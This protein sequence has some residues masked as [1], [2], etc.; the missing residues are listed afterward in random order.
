VPPS[1]RPVGI[2]FALSLVVGVI[3]GGC[4]S[5]KPWQR[6]RLASA[7]MAVPLSEPALAVGYRA[8]LLESR[9]GGGLPGVAAG[10]G[11]GCTQ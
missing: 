11:C 7:A 9:V 10:G 1:L 6:G 4:V 8:K 5:V 2:P 3:L